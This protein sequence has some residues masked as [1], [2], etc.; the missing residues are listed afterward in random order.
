MG[1]IIK[2]FLKL[3]Q[4]PVPIFG[5]I[6]ARFKPETQVCDTIHEQIT[7]NPHKLGNK[8]DLTRI[9]RLV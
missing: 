7:V 9:T 4:E 8:F 6:A 2:P 3:L 5:V 1:P